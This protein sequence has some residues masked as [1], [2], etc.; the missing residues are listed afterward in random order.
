MVGGMI[1]VKSL[2]ATPPSMTSQLST[3]ITTF[4]P[5]LGIIALFFV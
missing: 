3:Y 5:I 4:L 1:T 2:L